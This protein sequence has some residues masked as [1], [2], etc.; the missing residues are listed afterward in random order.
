MKTT[1]VTV[2][3]LVLAVSAPAD[4]GS[5]PFNPKARVLEPNQRALIACNG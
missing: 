3:I 4:M 1:P 5:I 2:A